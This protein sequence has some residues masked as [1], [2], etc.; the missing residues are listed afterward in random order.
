MN[1]EQL[2][3]VIQKLGD[4]RKKAACEAAKFQMQD[5][6]ATLGQIERI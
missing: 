3:G 5:C 2:L 1:K 6:D 4:M